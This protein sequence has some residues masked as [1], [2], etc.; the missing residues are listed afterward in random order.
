MSVDTEIVATEPVH[1]EAVVPVIE[2]IVD[3]VVPVSVPPL[4]KEDVEKIVKDVVKLA[5]KELLEEMKKSSPIASLDKD[6]DG[7]ISI[8]EVKE[9]AVAQVAKLGCASSCVV[10]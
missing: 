7:N 2:K 5:L 4:L 3:T 6:G 1:M 9:A 8:D 10:A